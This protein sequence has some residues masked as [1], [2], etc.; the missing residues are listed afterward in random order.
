M[1]KD[2]RQWIDEKLEQG[3]DWKAIQA[4]LRLDDEALEM[5]SDL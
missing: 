3:L 2:A 5:A 4:L 1:S